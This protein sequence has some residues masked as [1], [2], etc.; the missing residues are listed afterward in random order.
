M[1]DHNSPTVVDAP[2]VGFVPT[3]GP[4][5]FHAPPLVPRIP[6]RTFRAVDRRALAALVAGMFGCSL[7]WASGWTDVGGALYALLTGI[8]LIASGVLGRRRIEPFSWTVLAMS[9]GVLL[10]VRDS[11]WLVLLNICALVVL[12]VVAA[13]TSHTGSVFD[14]QRWWIG[15]RLVV[16]CASFVRAF[17]VAAHLIQMAAPKRSKP[18]SPVFGD[19]EDRVP[20]AGV[21]KR[22]AVI[23]GKGVLLALPL[24]L[25]IVPLLMTGDAVFSNLLTLPASLISELP[26]PS[27]SNWFA[28]VWGGYLAAVLLAIATA[29][30]IVRRETSATTSTVEFGVADGIARDRVFSGRDV[31]SAMWLVNLVL[32]AFAGSQAIAA[33]SLAQRI[34]DEPL[35]YEAIAKRGFFPLLFASV[36]ILCSFMVAHS[37][38]SSETRSTIAFRI[39]SQTLVVLSLVLVLAA[40]RRLFMGAEIWGL[41]MLRV[42]SQTFAIWVATVFIGIGVWQLRPAGR[43]W[44]PGLSLTAAAVLLMA[45]NLAPIERLVV[46]WNVNQGLTTSQK[47]GL[48]ACQYYDDSWHGRNDDAIAELA[49]WLQSEVTAGRASND[50]ARRLLGCSDLPSDIASGSPSRTGLRWNLASSSGNAIRAKLCPTFPPSFF[51]DP[52]SYPD[53]VGSSSSP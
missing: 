35:S 45:L 36:L 25:C 32:A 33:T 21:S 22:S 52:S 5:Q 44:V 12:F 23:S 4:L 24:L 53:P 47:S 31:A 13:I 1:S 40:S 6:A 30:A 14:A 34:V 29:G 27:F 11:P 18:I 43:S 28:L 38:V 20:S 15:D 48:S 39:P 26:T 42:L 17:S 3:S 2:Q 16:L 10:V 19:G 37:L 9:F 8:S 49:P 41:T 50:C 46:R 7:G 51:N